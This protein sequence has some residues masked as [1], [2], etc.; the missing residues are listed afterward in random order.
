MIAR[1]RITKR[2]QWLDIDLPELRAI[3]A[4][5]ACT[6]MMQLIEF[7]GGEQ[8]SKISRHNHGAAGGGSPDHRA[9]LCLASNAAGAT[10]ERFITGEVVGFCGLLQ[11]SESLNSKQRA[12]KD[13]A[14]PS[15]RRV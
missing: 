7:F 11:L 2:A 3:P 5:W 6:L 9:A 1:E 14:H 10:H 12:P 13:V 4:W 15:A 8:K